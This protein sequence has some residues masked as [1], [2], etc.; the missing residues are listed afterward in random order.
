[1]RPRQN[2]HT[3]TL[4]LV[5]QVMPFGAPF[6]GGNILC[7]WV[8]ESVCLFVFSPIVH[9][10]C[11]PHASASGGDHRPHAESYARTHNTVMSCR[12]CRPY[13]GLDAHRLCIQA[14]PNCSVMLLVECKKAPT[15]RYS[16]K[17]THTHCKRILG[18]TSP[19]ALFAGVRR[20]EQNFPCVHRR[21]LFFVVP[22]DP[23]PPPR[24]CSSSG[25]S[26]CVRISRTY[27]RSH[28]HFIFI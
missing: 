18:G 8:F 26:P 3:I 5:L 11:C 13:C 23:P 9:R 25:V 28:R 24:T 7:A 12:L 19:F 14:G 1:M 6:R 16:H 21:I 17:H 10:R 27:A 20:T 2:G 22:S 4:R 15:Q